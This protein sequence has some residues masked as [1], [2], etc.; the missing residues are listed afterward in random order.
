MEE[1]H[2]MEIEG[3]FRKGRT[4]YLVDGVPKFGVAVGC[5]TVEWESP[6]GKVGM[7]LYIKEEVVDQFI[8][9]LLE[10]KKNGNKD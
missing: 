9:G 2:E 5:V 4:D 10:A 8:E 6:N 7:E 3:V 1:K